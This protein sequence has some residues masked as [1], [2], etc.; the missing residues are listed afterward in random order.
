[1]GSLMRFLN[2]PTRILAA[3][4]LI[5]TA[6][7]IAPASA[8]ADP[9]AE[10]FI[11]NIASRAIEILSDKS[12][13]AEAREEEFR[14]L[15]EANAELDR[16]GVF[17]LGQ[18]ARTTTPEERKQYLQLVREFIVKIY[19]SRLSD[20]SNEKFVVLDSIP[21]GSKEVI[22]SSRIEFTNGREPVP[23]EWRLTKGN[24]YKVF[25]VKVVGIWMAQE[26]RDTFT[27]V[28]R[29]NNG[30]F[31]ALL[32]HIQRQIVEGVDEPDSAQTANSN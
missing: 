24:G 8:G 5:A 31:Q 11:D 25:D 17:A 32:D 29:N 1:M 4:W 9:E 13:T 27:S 20:Y 16:I 30:N 3:A 12:L 26:Q 21:K 2:R 19:L 7:M 22:V 14:T 15:L 28:I 18:Y 10:A 6:F 23:V